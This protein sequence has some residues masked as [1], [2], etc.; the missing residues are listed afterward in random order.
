LLPGFPLRVD[1]PKWA[2]DGVPVTDGK[3]LY[4]A[5]RFADVRPHAHVACFDLRNGRPIW[6][7]RVCSGET[8]ARGQVPEVTHNLL[9]LDHDTLYFNTN[10]G[11]VAALSTDDGHVRWVTLYPRASMSAPARGE[12]RVHR[13]RDTTPC[14][15]HHDMLLVAPSDCEQLFALD[16]AT[17]GLLWQTQLATDTLDVVHLL[18]VVGDHLIAAGRRL[19]WI[20]VRTGQPSR[21][22]EVNP[23]P[24]SPNAEVASFGRGTIAGEYVYWPARGEHDEIYVFDGRTGRQVRQPINLTQA[25]AAAGNLVIAHG[26][27][28]VAASDRMYVFE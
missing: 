2:F 12:R 6:R 27:L 1:D 10:L 21:R 18:G 15:L 13:L 7:R 16:V 26:R 17:G 19:W 23:F 25:D 22:V 24:R 4:V 5:M 20:D 28:I 11:G 3:R 9:T 8:L 14:V